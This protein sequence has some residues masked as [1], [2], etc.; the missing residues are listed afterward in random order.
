MKKLI[1]AFKECRTQIWTDMDLIKYS[2]VS[3][4][5]GAFVGYCL[6]SKPV[7]AVIDCVKP[8]VG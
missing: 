2:I 5:F 7:Q 6:G 3:W 4:L 1:A 8:L